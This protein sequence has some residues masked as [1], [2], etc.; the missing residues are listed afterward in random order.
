MKKGQEF[1][2]IVTRVE[3]PNKGIVEIEGRRVIVKNALP[4][5]KIRFKINKI[6][7]NKVEARLLEVLEQSEL[8]D[9][10]A[11]CAHFG[12]CGGCSYQTLSYENQLDLKEIGRASCRERV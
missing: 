4:G 3:F 2:G 5:Q 7:K 12:P 6:R 10:Q 11:K 8:E 9:R 1:E